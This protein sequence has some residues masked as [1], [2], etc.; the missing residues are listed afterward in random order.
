M[1][2]TRRDDI[3]PGVRVTHYRKR[4]VIAFEADAD[5]VLVLGIFH[6]GQDY[7]SESFEEPGTQDPSAP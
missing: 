4:T 1:R 5:P 2:G 7:E 3:R 6:G